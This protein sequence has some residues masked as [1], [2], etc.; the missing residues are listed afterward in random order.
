MLFKGSVCKTAVEGSSTNI[1]GSILSVLLPTDA[2]DPQA[3]LEATGQTIMG[4][5]CVSLQNY[6][7]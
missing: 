3:S 1:G 2:H 6:C 7:K 4:Y 5:T